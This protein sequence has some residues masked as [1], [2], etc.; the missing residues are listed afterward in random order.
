MRN[1]ASSTRL[2]ITMMQNSPISVGFDSKFLNMKILHYFDGEIVTYNL[3]IMMVILMD[4]CANQPSMNA[5]TDR[6]C[7]R[8]CGAAKKKPS[9]G[10]NDCASGRVG[11]D[12]LKVSGAVN[13]VNF[14]E[15]QFSDHRD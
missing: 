11:S 15:V 8:T 1:V 12:A 13:K 5:S 14:I 4:S 10:T 2:A 7:D 9:C 6:A 3:S